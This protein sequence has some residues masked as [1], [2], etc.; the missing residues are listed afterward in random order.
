MTD[1]PATPRTVRLVIVLEATIDQPEWTEETLIENVPDYIES[2]LSEGEGRSRLH[3]WEQTYRLNTSKEGLTVW[4]WPVFL[5]RLQGGGLEQD[6]AGVGRIYEPV[7][8]GSCNMN[9][10]PLAPCPDGFE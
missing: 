10:P 3:G 1:T 4:T 9:H 8:C 5:E 7:E 6:I 2:C